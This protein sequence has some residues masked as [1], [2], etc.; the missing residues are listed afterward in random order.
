MR[1]WREEVSCAL[2]LRARWKVKLDCDPL[3]RV[4]RDVGI[5]DRGRPYPWSLRIHCRTQRRVVGLDTLAFTKR[6][7]VL[8]DSRWIRRNK[9]DGPND[10]A[11]KRK[12]VVRTMA[13]RPVE[14][15]VEMKMKVGDVDAGFATVDVA[16]GCGVDDAG[17]VRT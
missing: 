11:G 14:V 9:S 1:E 2:Y 7:P 6:T 5:E 15:A 8:P 12:L 3:R 10:R 13:Y 4:R 16:A 17:T